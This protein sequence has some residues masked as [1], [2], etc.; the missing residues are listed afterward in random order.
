M[1]PHTTLPSAN[2]GPR[3]SETVR[4]RLTT[5]HPRE[6]AGAAVDLG[7]EPFLIG[8]EG[9]VGLHLEHR[10]VSRR[11]LS[12]EWDGKTGTHLAQDLGSKNGSALDGVPL[13]SERRRLENGTVLRAGDVLLVYEAGLDFAVDDV[14]EVS[15]EALPGR[16]ASLRPLRAAMARA[17][18]DRAPLLLVGETGTGK[19]WIAREVHRLS[20]RG[21][22]LVSV[23]CAALAPT[24]VES[25]LFGHVKGAFTGASEPR[26]GLFR[27]AHGGSLF[28]DEIGEL[29]L[30][31]QPKLLRALQEGEVQPVGSVARH[32]VDVR[33]LAATHRDLARAAEEGQFRADLY[34]RLSLW[35]LRVPPLRARRVDLLDWIERLATKWRRESG[36]AARFELSPDAAEALLLARWPLNLRGLDRLVRELSMR[37]VGDEGVQKA[38]LPGWVTAAPATAQ[39]DGGGEQA[40]AKQPVPTREEFAAAFAALQGNVSGLARKFRRDRR[41]IYRWIEAYGLRASR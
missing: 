25:E 33:V 9:E 14:L 19:E 4:A 17:S 35:E 20:G 29:P 34:A 23:N 39:S 6:V 16:A 11:H 26:H 36:Q 18:L 30:P 22:P 13:E 41:Q 31:L 10:S 27:A 3:P 5:V 38:E 37:R 8:R 12:I 7:S 2:R 32:Q 15:R 28:L 1:S 21:G 24:L 40:K